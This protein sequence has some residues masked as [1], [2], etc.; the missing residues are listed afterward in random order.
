LSSFS[1]HPRVIPILDDFVSSVEDKGSHSEHCSLVCKNIQQNLLHVLGMVQDLI[2]QSAQL[3]LYFQGDES[4][5]FL[6]HYL[7]ILPKDIQNLKV[8]L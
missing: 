7:I 2:M 4:T 5:S 8:P 3:D 6:K 1:T